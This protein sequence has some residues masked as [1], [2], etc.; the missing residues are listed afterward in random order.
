MTDIAS[1]G[2]R[3]ESG[4]AQTAA[5]RLDRLAESAQTAEQAAGGTGPAFSR[6]GSAL[7]NFGENAQVVLGRLTGLSGQ[8]RA[9]AQVLARLP[10][11]LASAAAV[12]GVIG[13]AFN[14]GQRESFEFAKAL[15][16]TG[17]QSGIAAGELKLLADRLDDIGGSRS[18]AVRALTEL[19]SR[20][21]DADVIRRYTAAI[22]EL[23]RVGG[24][25]VSET[26]EAFAKLADKPLE[27]AIELQKATGFLTPA[28]YEQ[29]KAL[30]SQG[31]KS[32]AAALAQKAYAAEITRQ[33]Q[34]LRSEL[35]LISRDRKSVV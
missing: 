18:D 21:L 29:I 25:A 35:P 13:K 15:A 24:P 16:L 4:E 2:L 5:E 14:D 1:L 20:G 32:E 31:K 8:Q 22:Q 11:P 3:V 6:A 10:L 28:L 23:E 34:Q 9:F 7:R 12:L 26:A 30:E 33:A 19:T 17:R 27:A